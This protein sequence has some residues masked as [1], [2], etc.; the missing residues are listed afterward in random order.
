MR[1]PALT[2]KLLASTAVVGAAAAIAGLGTYATWTSSTPAQ[3]QTVSAG[4]VQI[5]LGSTNRLTTNATGLVPG[6]IVERAVDLDGP[7]SGV[8]GI[9]SISLGVS[10]GSSTLLDSDTTNG[11]HINVDSCPSSSTVNGTTTYDTT[12]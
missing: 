1:R 3:N 12:S 8:S 9:G 5:A 6:D 4:T 7:S 10:V 2:P 11:L